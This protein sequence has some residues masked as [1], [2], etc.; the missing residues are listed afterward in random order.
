MV[1]RRL[2]LT[3]V[4]INLM[5]SMSGD[6]DRSRYPTVDEAALKGVVR[7]SLDSPEPTSAQIA[8]RQRNIEI[9]RTMGLPVLEHLPVIE[10]EK[11]LAPR[12]PREVAERCVAVFICAIKGEVEG[13]DPPFIDDLVK[14]F[15]ASGFF[16]PKERAFLQSAHPPRRDLIDFAWRYECSHVLLWALGHL[17]TLRPPGEICDVAREVGILRDLGA[18]FVGKARIRSQA[19]ILE[20]ADLYYRLHWAA[21]ELRLKGSPSDKIHEGIIRERH[22]ALNWLIRYMNQSWDDVE[23]DT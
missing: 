4:A 22:R 9:V 7:T 1:L 5:P 19:E 16:S 15:S 8:R 6:P 12:Q 17:D 20:Q 13:K 3:L 10:D 14:R 11:Q 23:T 18:D 21:I 2:L